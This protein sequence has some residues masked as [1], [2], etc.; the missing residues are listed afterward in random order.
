[1]AQ[2]LLPLF[3]CET[4]YLTPTLGVF[5]KEDLVY[6]M[7]N[8]VPIFSHASSD[9]NRFRYVSS[10]LLLQGLCQ[11]VD[12]ARVFHVST[13]SVRRWKNKLSE[14]GESAFFSA[15]IS[16][17]SA[18]KLLPDVLARIQHKLDDGASVN[19]IAKKENISEGSIRYAIK[20]DKLKKNSH[21][22]R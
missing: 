20:Q 22:Q 2:L 21:S 7:H 14:V 19:S 1:M 4:A 11:N 17:S 6:Y 13:D 15:S 12:I 3:P 16:H 8:G 10:H 5:R 9:I 18:H